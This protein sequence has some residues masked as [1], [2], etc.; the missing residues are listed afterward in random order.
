MVIEKG[1]DMVKRIS[2]LFLVALLVFLLVGV[3]ACKENKEKAE[4]ATMV[5]N[6]YARYKAGEAKQPFMYDEIVER[7][8]NKFGPSNHGKVSGEDTGSQ[9]GILYWVDGDYTAEEVNER[10]AKKKKMMGLAISFANGI[11]VD[12]YYGTMEGWIYEK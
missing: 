11:A 9:T 1:E 10:A 12:S 6:R 3:S 7:T 2:K 4:W 5:A 8:T